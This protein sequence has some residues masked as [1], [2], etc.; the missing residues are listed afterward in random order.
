MTARGR[1]NFANGRLVVKPPKSKYGNAR[2]EVDGEMF[3]SASEAQRYRQL[4]IMQLAG[5]IS[6][7]TRQVSFELAPAV[8]IN[9]QRKRALTYRADFSYTE[10]E[11]GQRIVEDKK[12]ALTDVYKIKRHLMKSIHGIDIRET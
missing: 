2:T 9:G 8:M 5:L 10:T 4:Q 7:L 6:G 3:D 1:Y 11:S 12:G